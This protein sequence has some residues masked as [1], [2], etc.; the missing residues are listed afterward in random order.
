[1]KK[2]ISFG[3]TAG[4][5]LVCIAT[6]FGYG[7]ILRR[8][9]KADL[10]E[11]EYHCQGCDGW[12]F[13]HLLFFLALGYLDPDR[14]LFYGGRGILWEL[15]ET[16][17]GQNDIRISGQRLKLIGESGVTA[18]GTVEYKD[19]AWWYGRTSDVAFDL[20]GYAIG[21]AINAAQFGACLVV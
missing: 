13:S 1:M 8:M 5:L 18:D 7:Y 4:L 21:T 12:G 9:K 2:L 19:E 11:T 16:F 15:F 3:G 10:L 6:I 17:V 14:Y 20:V